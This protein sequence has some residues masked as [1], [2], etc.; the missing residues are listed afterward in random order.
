MMT[1]WFVR[2]LLSLSM[3][4]A[5]AQANDGI[6]LIELQTWVDESSGSSFEFSSPAS[7]RDGLSYQAVTYSADGLNQ[8]ALIVH[9][10][11]QAPA[12]G[13]PVLIFNH[14]Y[15]PNPPQYGVSA[16]GTVSRPG[17]YYRALVSA[18][19]N[20]GYL[21]VAAD[22]RGHNRSEGA[23][24]TR[25]AYAAHYYT[26]DVIAAYWAAMK[27]PNVN[28]RQVVM[29]G[30]SMGGGI[31]QRAALVLGDRLA[32]ASI[33]STAGEDFR[34]YWMTEALGDGEVIDSNLA[35]KPLFDELLA[36]LNHG[37]YRFS[38]LEVAPQIA[39]VH[40]PLIIQHA[41]LDPATAVENSIDLAGRLYQADKDY[42]LYLYNGSDHLFRGETFNRAIERDQAFFI[43]ARR[44]ANH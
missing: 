9:P 27:L 16:D 17:D 10:S 2:W 44:K 22:Y 38:D 25:R 39:A 11:H 37:D 41:R 1:R 12:S 7:E 6:S 32:A 4:S 20:L 13:W 21:V 28:P 35:S 33:W 3:I 30:H 34:R 29:A 24:Y 31:T 14:G 40:A 15:H 19:A 43:R 5:L 36:E 8:F 26:R 23:E 42:E 18:Y